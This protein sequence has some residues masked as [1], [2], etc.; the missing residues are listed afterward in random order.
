MRTE[1]N[2]VVRSCVLV[3]AYDLILSLGGK[4]EDLA[5]EAGVPAEALHD[6]N[7]FIDSQSVARFLELAA[8]RCNCR[9]FGIRLSAHQGWHILGPL[10]LLVRQAETI[11]DALSDLSEFFSFFVSVMTVELHK[12]EGGVAFCYERRKRSGMPSVQTVELGLAMT[13]REIGHM[14][15]RPWKPDF[16]QFRHSCPLERTIYTEVFGENVFFEQERN[17]ILIQR[18]ILAAPMKTARASTRQVLASHMANQKILEDNLLEHRVEASIRLLLMHSRCNVSAVSKVLGM[19]PRT[20]QNSLK[21]QGVSYQSL[22]DDVRLELA[23]NY[24]ANTELKVSE[25]SDLLQFAYPSV[26][27]RFMKSQIGNTPRE[28][29]HQL[30]ANL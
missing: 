7:L 2:T 28:L 10:W 24:L 25:I 11:G 6:S 23:E 30:K 13:V 5:N 3:G 22:L 20:L 17:A 12:E 8:L 4:P 14:L 27:S 18:D 9:E 15:G 16:V 26:F 1:S 19:S 29:R 21:N